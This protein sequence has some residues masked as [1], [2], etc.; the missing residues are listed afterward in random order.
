MALPIITPP[1]TLAN[2]W[3]K[4]IFT[5][6]VSDWYRIIDETSTGG[7]ISG[8]MIISGTTAAGNEWSIWFLFQAE[9]AAGTFA[10]L[11]QLYSTN[12]HDCD[13]VKTS[14]DGVNRNAVDIHFSAFGRP[15]TVEFRAFPLANP[16]TIPV[17]AIG[18][19]TDT[20]LFPGPNGLRTT[21]GIT[22]AGVTSAVVKTNSGGDF[23]AA[24]ANTDYALPATVALST[25][26][27]G[28]TASFATTATD[29]TL[30]ITPAGTL[31]ALTVA[32]PAN[33]TAR[34]GQR[35][36]VCCTQIITALTLSGATT[37][38]GFAPTALTAGQSFG[39]VKVAANT[40]FCHS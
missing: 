31:A 15:V 18:L 2:L 32:L 11:S 8:Q 30:Y 24:V 25:P 37:F 38:I 40:W 20:E 16:I 4:I 1:G 13:I 36:R 7:E 14:T 19:G 29:Q 9:G 28:Q 17:V 12:T 26:T 23:I 35:C 33:A 39:L 10:T 5:P 3:R 27:T 34:T 6:T 22:Q 21:G